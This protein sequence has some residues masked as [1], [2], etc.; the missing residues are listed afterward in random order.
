MTF[1]R[2]TRGDDIKAACGQ[3]SG[4]VNNLAKQSLGQKLK[5]IN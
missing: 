3:L 5:T 4:K 2:T 1:I